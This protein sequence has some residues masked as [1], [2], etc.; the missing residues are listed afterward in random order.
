M[1]YGKKIW[2]NEGLSGFYKGIGVV[3]IQ[4]IIWATVLIIFDTAGI[5]F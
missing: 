1:R 3:P 2:K 5:G 4:S